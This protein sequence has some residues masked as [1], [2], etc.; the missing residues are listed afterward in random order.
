MAQH[1]LPSLP[2]LVALTGASGVIYGIRLVE[3]LVRRGRRVDLLVSDGARRV[4]DAE[5]SLRAGRNADPSEFLNLTEEELARIRMFSFRDIAAL[6][7]SGTYRL[8]GMVIIPASMKT[9]AAV[10]HGFSDNL[11]TRAADVALK[12]KTPL[13]IVPREAPLSEIHLA[14]LLTLARAGAVVLP[15]MPGFYH[16]P[17]S[18]DDLVDFVVMKVFDSLSLPH[19]F[20]HAW[21]GEM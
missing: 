5:V 1:D 12:E 8:Q 11:I 18:I 21:K 10:A 14:N 17:K 19:D 9:C 2:I 16:D 13:V 7:A 6:P 4:M 3:T 20:P 15:A